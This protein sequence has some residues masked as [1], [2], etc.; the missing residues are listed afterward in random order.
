MDISL[1]YNRSVA[2]GLASLQGKSEP[3]GAAYLNFMEYPVDDWVDN[4]DKSI[5]LSNKAVCLTKVTPQ[6]QKPNN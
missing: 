1:P 3:A 6:Q 2:F 5:R 4:W